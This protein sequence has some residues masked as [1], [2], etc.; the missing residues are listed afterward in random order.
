[1][2]KPPG[3]KKYEL[4][5]LNPVHREI[6]RRSVLGE[7]VSSIAKALG[8]TREMVSYTIS[9]PVTREYMRELEAQRDASTVNVGQQLRSLSPKAIGVLTEALD[10]DMGGRAQDHLRFKAATEVLDRAG[11]P[12][13]TRSEATVATVHTSIDH[14]K[15]LAEEMRGESK[16]VDVKFQ[17]LDA[18]TK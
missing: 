4:Q 5:Q 7:A 1:M 2:P 10:G 12:K 17:P 14:I 9:S 16:V 3:R 15:R 11:Y 13:L 8:V 18:K 6:A